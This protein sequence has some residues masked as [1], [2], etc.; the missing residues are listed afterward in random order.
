MMKMVSRSEGFTLLELIISFTIIAL[1]AGMVFSSLRL[2]L[3]SYERSQARLEVEAERRVLFNHLRMQIG[4]LFPLQPTISRIGGAE[5]AQMQGDLGSRLSLSQTPLFYGGPD[6]VTFISVAPL[7]LEQ[8][9]G[10]TVVR[11]G[12]AQNDSGTYYLGSMEA[13]YTGLETFLAM[14]ELPEGVPLRIVNNIQF[15]EFQYYGYNAEAQIYDWFTN[16]SGEEFGAVP[17]AIR[18][19]FDDQYIVAPVNATYFGGNLRNR[20]RGLTGVR[21]NPRRQ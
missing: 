15:L 16:W 5:Q 10:L 14:A 7:V 18:I 4:S 9:P 2:A 19:S 21:P 11:Y 13:P 17:D 20:L 1:M 12:L 3:N 6:F 8:N